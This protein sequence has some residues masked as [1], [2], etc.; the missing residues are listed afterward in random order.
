MKDTKAFI[1][2]KGYI[3]KNRKIKVF[4]TAFFS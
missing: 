4:Y 2:I 3:Y 1:N